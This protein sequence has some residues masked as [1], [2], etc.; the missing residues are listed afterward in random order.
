MIAILSPAKNIDFTPSFVELPLSV[1]LFSEQANRLAGHLKNYSI[2]QLV[3]LYHV[4]R[5]IVDLNYGRWAHWLQQPAADA[6]RPA[7]TAFNGEVY[8]GLDARSFSAEQL[9][10]ADKALRILSGLYGVL[11]PLDGIQAYRLEMGTKID[12][13]GHRA[14]YP[15]WRE[16][17]TKAIVDAVEASSGDKA[18]VNLASAEYAKVIDQKKLPFPVIDIEFK[19]EVNG[20]LKNITVYAKRARGL[21]ARFMVVHNIQCVEHLKAFDSEGYS[22]SQHHS[23]QHRW[24]FLR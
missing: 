23:L 15:L 11:S 18:L 14:L 1:P 2:E 4:N 24:V 5:S 19:Q 16:R 22:F 17:V 12:F 13:D 3:D 8:R 20:S 21:M 10:K 6:L 9:A 7:V